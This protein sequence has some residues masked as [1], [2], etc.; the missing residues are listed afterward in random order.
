MEEKPN[1][2]GPEE[3]PKRWEKP[4]VSD[5][6]LESDE[7]VLGACFSPSQAINQP[8]CGPASYGQC[9]G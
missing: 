6:S 7:D 5:V 3:A 2:V 4:V 1:T 9:L 8:L